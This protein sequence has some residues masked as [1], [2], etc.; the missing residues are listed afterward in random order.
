MGGRDDGPVEG[1]EGRLYTF[2]PFCAEA[3][4]GVIAGVCRL[5]APREQGCG[6]DKA[7]IHAATQFPSC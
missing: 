5:P 2:Q 4:H 3:H 1:V 7:F 6:A